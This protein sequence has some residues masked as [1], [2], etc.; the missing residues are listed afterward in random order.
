MGFVIN[1]IYSMAYGLHKMQRAVCPGMAGLCDAMRPVD[2]SK[3]LEFLIKT[4][5][6][7]V[8]GENIYF[9]ENGDAPG[10]YAERSDQVLSQTFSSSVSRL[11]SEEVNQSL[12][13]SV[14]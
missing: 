12:I 4:N 7:G 10:R 5:F 6:T 2:G 8:S 13:Q 11:T 14:S 9:D 1:A 3:L